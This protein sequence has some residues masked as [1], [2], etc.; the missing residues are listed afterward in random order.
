LK[1]S[2]QPSNRA[3]SRDHARERKHAKFRKERRYETS[4]PRLPN[5]F[6]A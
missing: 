4:V 3:W 1:L 6:M 5:T 2:M